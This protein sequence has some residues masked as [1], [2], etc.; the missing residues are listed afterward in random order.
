MTS[1]Y[2]DSALSPE[3]DIAQIPKRLD[4]PLVLLERIGKTF[5]D[6]KVI[7]WVPDVFK[8]FHV[9]LLKEPSDK[10]SNATQANI[11]HKYV[12]LDP[13]FFVG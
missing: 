5:T 2:A 9:L 1:F 13:D 11:A 7:P 10:S 12:L 6:I 8:D 3:I 4:G